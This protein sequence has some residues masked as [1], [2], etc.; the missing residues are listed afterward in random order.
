MAESIRMFLQDNPFVTAALG[1]F[2][3]VIAV[4]VVRGLTAGRSHRE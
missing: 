1:F 2:A 3:S 4:A